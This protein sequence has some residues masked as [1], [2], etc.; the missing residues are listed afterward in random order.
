MVLRPERDRAELVYGTLSQTRQT[1]GTVTRGQR[2]KTHHGQG[3]KT[4]RFQGA[5]KLAQ[6]R[7]QFR[8][9]VCVFLLYL[10]DQ[11][12]QLKKGLEG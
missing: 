1:G 2:L 8:R 7:Q 3:A 11:L 4:V 9:E 5:D 12:I 10:D 6:N